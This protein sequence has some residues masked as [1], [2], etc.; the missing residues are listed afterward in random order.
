MKSQ[1]SHNATAYNYLKKVIR[2]HPEPL[3]RVQE[4]M[5]KDYMQR[6]LILGNDE[7]VNNKNEKKCLELDRNIRAHATHTRTL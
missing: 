7:S 3:R 6:L 2:R 4:L 5:G 1:F